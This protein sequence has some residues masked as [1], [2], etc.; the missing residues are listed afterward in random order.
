M[1]EDRGASTGRARR[2]PPPFRR[3]TVR[4]V[5]PG[6]GRLVRV[7]LS[8]PELAGMAVP[9]PAASIRVLLPA[10]G[11]H[12]VVIPGW[13][14]NEFRDA[15]GRRAAIRTLTPARLD[16]DVDE[17]DVCVVAHGEGL[18]ARWAAGARAGQGAA[19]SGPGR[20]FTVDPDAPAW[21]LAGDE[22]AFPA[23]VQ[24]LAAIP[25]GRPVAAHRAAPAPGRVELP[26]RPGGRVTWHDPA[27]GEAPC[28]ALVDGVVDAGLPA[29]TYVW[30]AGE[31]AAMQRL[32]RHLL[33]E[34][35]LPRAQVA[36]RGYWKAGRSADG[37]DGA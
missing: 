15:T 7:T 19:V 28:S 9:E 10:P 37:S 25:L 11:A 14:G 3:V 24:V 36:V 12:D 33:D 13:N 18:A 26:G 29:T 20:G 17:L 34:R 35:A 8:G 27:R 32:R 16:A 5:A 30:A 23:I 31:A 2:P 6:G 22:A 4:R 21:L 1:V